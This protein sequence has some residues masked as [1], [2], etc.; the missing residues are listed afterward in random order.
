MVDKSRSRKQHGAGI[1]LTLA[2]K[3]ARIHGSS[4]EFE[5]DGQSWTKVSFCLKCKGEGSDEQR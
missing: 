5:S 1:G 3:I 4:L 2:E